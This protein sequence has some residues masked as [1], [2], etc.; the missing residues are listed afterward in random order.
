MLQGKRNALPEG[1]QSSG[2][3]RPRTGLLQARFLDIS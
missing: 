1:G 2:L 3:R